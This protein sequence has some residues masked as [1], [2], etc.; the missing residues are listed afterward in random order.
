[1]QALASASNRAKT[2]HTFPGIG[3]TGGCH[4][5]PCE[6]IKAQVLLRP[7]PFHPFL[8]PPSGW[9]PRPRRGFTHNTHTTHNAGRPPLRRCHPRRPAPACI[10]AAPR[11]SGRPGSRTGRGECLP[12]DCAPVGETV[13]VPHRSSRARGPRGPLNGAWQGPM[14]DRKRS[15]HAPA[16]WAPPPTL[17]LPAAP[18]PVHSICLQRT[19]P[20]PSCRARAS[21]P[22]APPPQAS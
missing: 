14:A 3:G 12:A 10:C 6:H 19:L 13:N 18:A 20:S 5:S 15:M 1:M 9:Q 22:P 17:P 7:T 2:P 11:R 21:S 16:R 8:H 4:L